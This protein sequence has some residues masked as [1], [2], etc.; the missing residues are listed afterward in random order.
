MPQ[1]DF[2]SEILAQCRDGDLFRNPMKAKRVSMKWNC[3]F[4]PKSVYIFCR[5]YFPDVWMLRVVSKTS[6]PSHYTLENGKLKWILPNGEMFK[7]LIW[8]LGKDI[9][10]EL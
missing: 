7:C 3:N 1:R 8:H 4:L 6:F 2:N 9:S 5:E 10:S